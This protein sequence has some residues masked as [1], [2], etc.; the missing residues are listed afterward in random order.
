MEIRKQ[1]EGENCASDVMEKDDDEMRTA[2]GRTTDTLLRFHPAA[3]Q[4]ELDHIGT[5][6]TSSRYVYAT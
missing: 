3:E 4:P 5:G 1:E 6:V 2:V